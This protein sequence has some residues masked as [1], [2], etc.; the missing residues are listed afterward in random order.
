MCV[1]FF[2]FLN[3]AIRNFEWLPFW[4]LKLWMVNEINKIDWWHCGILQIATYIILNIIHFDV[5][6]INT[7]IKR[8][9]SIYFEILDVLCVCDFCFCLKPKHYI[10]CFVW[11]LIRY[12]SCLF[13][14]GMLLCFCNLKIL[15]R[16]HWESLKQHSNT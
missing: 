4:N 16:W 14:L 11:H 12:V 7:N 13:F 9:G 1:F 5:F 2:L 6:N 3:M 15:S 8:W 10:V